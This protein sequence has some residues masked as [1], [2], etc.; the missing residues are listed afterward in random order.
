MA[1]N[2]AFGDGYKIYTNDVKQGLKEPCFFVAVLEPTRK[3]M[4][5]RRYRY[6]NP[7]CITY[8]P[9]HA[10]NN[11]EMLGVA[12]KLTEALELIT[13]LDGDTVRGT[14]IRFEIVDGN[15]QFFVNYNH[16]MIKPTDPT[17]MGDLDV[18]VGTMKG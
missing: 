18:T 1:L 11:T 4:I 9:R 7:F 2:A 12:E 14:G 6:D 3:Q 16:F 10:G 8:F 15:L 17:F 5:G 13:V